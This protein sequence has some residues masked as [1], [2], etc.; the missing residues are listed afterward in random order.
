MTMVFNLGVFDMA[1]LMDIIKGLTGGGQV[2]ADQSQL[3]QMATPQNPKQEVMGLLN[4][5]FKDPAVV[6]GIAGNIDVETGGTFDYKQKQ[7]G[8]GQGEGLFQFTKPEMK[9]A[10]K[11]Y[12][13]LTQSEDSARNQVYFV[14]SLLDS[15]EFYDVGSGHR[16]KL[17]KAFGSGDPE[18]VASEFSERF[19][20]PGEPHLERRMSSAKKIY[21]ESK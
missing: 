21:K 11:D 6:S 14:K 10:Y 15:N 19:E 2:Q 17:K 8:G 13:N 12:L 18:F 5:V 3:M 20:R 9:S 7:S 4:Q 16:S 1:G